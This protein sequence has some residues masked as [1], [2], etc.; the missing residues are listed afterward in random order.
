MYLTLF[1]KRLFFL[2]RVM[3]MKDLTLRIRFSKFQMTL[4][5]KQIVF[6]IYILLGQI[7]SMM[8]RFLQFAKIPHIDREFKLWNEYY[9]M[10]LP[11]F[12]IYQIS[13]M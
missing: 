10:N 13:H 3:Q 8:V 7:H 5:R 2:I 4:K 12:F 9:S 1:D 11:F 6:K